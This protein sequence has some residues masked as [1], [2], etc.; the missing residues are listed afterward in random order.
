MKKKLYQTEKEK[1]QGVE[2]I[3]KEINK[4]HIIQ[5]FLVDQ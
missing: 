2:M 1:K 4:K 5:T 3:A